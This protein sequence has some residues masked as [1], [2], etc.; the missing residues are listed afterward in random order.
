MARTAEHLTK[1][2]LHDKIINRLG[3]LHPG[4]ASE[5]NQMFTPGE[6]RNAAYA[7]NRDDHLNPVPGRTEVVPI[8]ATPKTMLDNLSS[9]DLGK[10]QHPSSLDD[11]SGDERGKLDAAIND[12]ATRTDGTRN[13]V[14]VPKDSMQRLQD[15][16]APAG[17]TA[18]AVGRVTQQFRRT[19]L[20]YSTHWMTQI[21]TEAGIR[22]MIAGVFDPR[23]L[24]VGRQLMAELKTDPE[25]QAALQEMTQAT[26]YG[27]DSNLSVHNPNPG[28]I[29]SAAHAKLFS[30]TSTDRGA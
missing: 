18:R 29:S 30:A 15:Q 8:T 2:E 16:F 3:I 4:R 25:G 22:G 20:P 6:A 27:Q 26:F 19:V 1:A 13:V 28:M 14:L 5:E 21:G 11:L 24:G 9:A 10:L 17:R 7:I 23:S 12:A